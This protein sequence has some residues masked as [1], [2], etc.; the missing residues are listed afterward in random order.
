MGSHEHRG[1]S[2]PE[3]SSLAR[4]AFDAMAELQTAGDLADLEAIARGVF[5][6]LGFTYFA[7]AQFFRADRTPDTQVLFGAF[8]PGWAQRYVAN[9][10]GRHSGIAREMLVSA[11]PYSWSDVLGRRTL[12]AESE[13]I[14]NEAREFRMKDGLFAPMRGA[15]GSYCAV[16]L[17]GEH[18]DPS[19]RFVRMAAQVLCGFY[20]SEGQRLLSAEGACRPVLTPRQRECLAWVRQGKSSTDIG[21][22]LGLSAPTVDGHIAE[23]CRRLGVRTRVQAVVEASVLGLIE[24]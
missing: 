17:S 13:R 14:W 7:A 9:D 5:E 3:Q 4:R 16:V 19:D 8:H 20:G 23:A 21:D 11:K 2:G 10:Y 1:L 22:L 6:D 12:S 18:V 15:D 24:R